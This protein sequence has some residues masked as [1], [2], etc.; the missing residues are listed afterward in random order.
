MLAGDQAK[1]HKRETLTHS[2][3]NE[4]KHI[5]ERGAITLILFHD[6]CT[7]T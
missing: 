3:L 6:H 4:L 5:E 1:T 7:C 2:K